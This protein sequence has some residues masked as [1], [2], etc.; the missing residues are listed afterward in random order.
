LGRALSLI[1]LVGAIDHRTTSKTW[2][3]VNLALD[4]FFAWKIGSPHC[5]HCS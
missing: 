2:K 5:V 3:V 4:Y 1:K